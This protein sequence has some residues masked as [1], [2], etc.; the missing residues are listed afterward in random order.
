MRSWASPVGAD[1][2]PDLSPE[3]IRG[4]TRAILRDL[5]A[6]EKM[7]AEGMIESGVRRFGAELEVFLVGAIRLDP[8]PDGVDGAYAVH[9]S[10][11]DLL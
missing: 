11:S 2:E 1:V 4:F 3:A 7:L 5:Q 8:A 9:Q 6:L 10:A